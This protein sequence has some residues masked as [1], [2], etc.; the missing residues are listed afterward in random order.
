MRW[1]ESI[2]RQ[3]LPDIDLDDGP[4]SR[5]R[6]KTVPKSIDPE[7][8]AQRNRWVQKSSSSGNAHLEEISEQLGFLSVATGTDIRY[9]GPSSGWF[10]TKYV[11]ANLGK[12][13]QNTCNDTERRPA[14]DDSYS[15]PM[16]LLEVTPRGLPSSESHARFLAKGYFK[17]IHLQYPFLYEPKIFDN[18]EQLYHNGDAI[19]PEDKF[20]VL[21]VLA[22]G[23]TIL[24]HRAKVNLYAEG[25]CA[26][27]ML[28]M[29]PI[30]REISM[31]SIQG[32]LLLQM[33][34]LHNKSS[35]LRL[36]SLHYHSLSF[37]SELGI[38]QNMRGTKF[39][40]PFEEEMRTRIFWTVYCMDRLL[41][42]LKG[43]P[44][45]LTDD[46]CHLRVSWQSI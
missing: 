17:T 10:F 35:G 43:R 39:F 6:R 2:I 36:W 15:V 7:E 38:F 26:S 42:T 19:K 13:V 40:S 29:D 46:T 16:E 27:A 5:P 21:M 20:Q 37:V 34:T 18:I 45:G 25:Y 3:N 44:E 28:I 33:Y 9:I 1:L 31:S 11:L 14:I 24:S 4:G 32:L 22:I 12:Q 30:F 8:D 41:S 23:A